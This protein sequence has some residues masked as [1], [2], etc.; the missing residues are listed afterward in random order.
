[1]KIPYRWLREFVDTEA[2]PAEAAERLT[3][4]GIEVASVTPVVTR[5]SGV[6][7]GEVTDVA[8][9]PAGG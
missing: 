8:S 3:M 2:T 6:V 1:M 7:V 4:A 5:L 9:H